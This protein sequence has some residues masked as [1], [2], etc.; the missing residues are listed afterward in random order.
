MYLN[1]NVFFYNIAF[2]DDNNSNNFQLNAEER[3]RN[4][5][6]GYS[7]ESYSSNKSETEDSAISSDHLSRQLSSSNDSLPME[8]NATKTTQNGKLAF[9]FFAVNLF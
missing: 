2:Y 1:S 8:R 3:R 6:H 5:R 4:N 9:V 7:T